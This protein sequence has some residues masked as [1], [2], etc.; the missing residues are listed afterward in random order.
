MDCAGQLDQ[1]HLFG[2]GPPL[3]DTL[4]GN[5]HVNV[6]GSVTSAP[7]DAGRPANPHAEVDDAASH[8]GFFP[9]VPPNHAAHPQDKPR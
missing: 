8:N 4:T 9:S 6:P 5:I 3:A 7:N 2:P 1:E